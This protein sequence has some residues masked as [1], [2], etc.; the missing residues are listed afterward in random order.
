MAKPD[1]HLALRRANPMLTSVSYRP[2]TASGE[3]LAYVSEPGKERL[4]M[5][6]NLGVEPLSMTFSVPDLHGRIILST[7]GDRSREPM[8]GE[9][10]LRPMRGSWSSLR[11]PRINRPMGSLAGQGA[12]KCECNERGTL[13]PLLG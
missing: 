10:D 11:M 9:V 7:F 5:A 8:R 3:L 1:L 6:L 12:A 2:I 13:V 4:L